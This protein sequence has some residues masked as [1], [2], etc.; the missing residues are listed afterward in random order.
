MT[1]RPVR[2]A[3]MPKDTTVRGIAFVRRLEMISLWDEY[4]LGFARNTRHG[5]ANIAHEKASHF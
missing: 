2:E 5:I 1:Y 3:V 4:L